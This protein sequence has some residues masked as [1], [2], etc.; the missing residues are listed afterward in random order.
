VG[1]SGEVDVPKDGP[2]ERRGGNDVLPPALDEVG[3]DVNFRLAWSVGDGKVPV[4]RKGRI[5]GPHRWGSMSGTY[6]S[7]RVGKY[8]LPH[9]WGLILHAPPYSKGLGNSTCACKWTPLF[10]E[11]VDSSTVAVKREYMSEKAPNRAGV[12]W[13]PPYP[14]RA[15]MGKK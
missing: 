1:K 13:R 7:P 4:A 3:K 9:G 8:V 6:T 14:G 10:A 11:C 12:K 2:S 5:S 15:K